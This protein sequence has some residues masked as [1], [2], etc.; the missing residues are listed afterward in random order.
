MQN[1]KIV[2]RSHSNRLSYASQLKSIC[3]KV[4]RCSCKVLNTGIASDLHNQI[5]VMKLYKELTQTQS[6]YILLLEDDIVFSVKAI[7]KI[8]SLIGRN[9]DCGWFTIPNSK[10]LHSAVNLENSE[11]IL[12]VFDHLYYSGSILIKTS[13]LKEYLAWYLMNY[14]V[15]EY[16]GFDVTLSSF[17]KS[18]I[19]YIRLVPGYFATDKKIKS[20][21]STQETKG[22]IDVCSSEIDPL[23][24]FG[25]MH[26]LFNI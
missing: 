8:N 15:F 9:K 20:S 23:F 24:N 13:L 7:A 21:I 16:P 10:V 1:L 25:D 11:Y 2:I 18:R 19:G 14:M 22:R 5:F 4:F 17:L 3:D 6:L 26:N 12:N